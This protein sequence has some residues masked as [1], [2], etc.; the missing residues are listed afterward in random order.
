MLS[1]PKILASSDQKKNDLEGGTPKDNAKITLSIL[2]GEKGPRRDTV[3]MN[4]GAA[5]YLAGKAGS[6]SEGIRLAEEIIDSGRAAAKLEEFK[7][8]SGK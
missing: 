7:E 3:L 5:F 1:N 8:A 4:A 2:K 6:I